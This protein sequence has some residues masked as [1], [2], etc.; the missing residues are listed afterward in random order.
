LLVRERTDLHA[1]DHECS[2]RITLPDKRYRESRAMA[3]SEMQSVT[4]GKFIFGNREVMDMYRFAVHDCPA[5]DPTASDGH[6][7]EV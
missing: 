4:L 3:L 7:F 5:G 2:D 6:V 1:P